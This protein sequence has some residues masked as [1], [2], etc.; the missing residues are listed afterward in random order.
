MKFYLN[1]TVYDAAL[2]RIRWIF[3][4]FPNVIAG[5]SGGKD[6]TV[7][8]NLCLQVAKEKDR[9]PLKVLFIDQEAEWQS[10]VNIIHEWM[11]TPGVDPKW[12]QMPIRLFNATSIYE[13]WLHCWDPV[14]SEKWIHPQDPV[15]IKENIYGT[16]RF[17]PIFGAI[18]EKEYPTTKT[19]YIAGVRAEENPTRYVGLTG[20]LTYKD[21]TWGSVLNKKREHYTLYPLYDWSY[22]DVWKAIHDNGWHYNTI[23]DKQYAYGMN[24]KDM[25]VSNIHH[26]TSVK[27]LFYLQEAEPDTYNRVVQR[28]AGIDMAGKMNE[29]DFFVHKLPFMFADWKEYRDYLLEKL[30]IREDWKEGL[31]KIF[32]RQERDYLPEL[33]EPTLY[34]SHINS[35]LTNDWEGIKLG[36]ADRRSN[37]MT[38]R[39]KHDNQRKKAAQ[40]ES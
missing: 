4:E 10:T 5:V 28:L 17:H 11:Y 36:N 9:L 21:A 6:S 40:N 7:I 18:L 27:S 1:K 16:D 35:I 39:K 3:D 12:Y 24:V 20:A 31:K 30:I 25:R 15:S 32:I 33:G 13:N 34:S 38:I 19:A 26:E 8:F 14:E 2:E 29:D 23:Y 37:W 22:T